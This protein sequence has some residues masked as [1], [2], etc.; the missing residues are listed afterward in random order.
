VIYTQGTGANS[1][2][3]QYLT[4]GGAFWTGQTN[5]GAGAQSSRYTVT[6]QKIY[7]VMGL[8][9]TYTSSYAVSSASIVVSSNSNT[10]FTGPRY[11]DIPFAQSLSPG[12]Y[13][14]GIGMTTSSSS[15]SG[16]IS[17]AGTAGMAVSLNGVSQTNLSFG[18]VG[19]VTSASD[20]QLQIGLGVWTTNSAI[21]STNSIAISQISQVASNLQLP[22][23]L[24]RQA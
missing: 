18:L 22:F 10:L 17:F 11:L 23:Q 19:A 13:W 14:L 3:L 4:S 12:N 15:Q 9:S 1:R 21:L 7:Q 16:N 20:H 5:C 24:I 6:V 2:S 8:Q